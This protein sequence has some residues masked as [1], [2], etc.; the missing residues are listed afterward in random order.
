MSRCPKF[1]VRSGGWTGAKL[2]AAAATWPGPDVP[3]EAGPTRALQTAWDAQM[4]PASRCVICAIVS[5][6]GEEAR[7]GR[8]IAVLLGALEFGQ[9]QGLQG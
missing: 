7:S 4:A 2:E 1:R 5:C 6:A 9:A 8:D 3:A